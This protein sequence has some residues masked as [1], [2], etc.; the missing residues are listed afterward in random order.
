MNDI[1]LEKTDPRDLQKPPQTRGYKKKERTRNRLLD[2]GNILLAEKG[3]TFTASDVSKTA[4]VSI[5]TFYNY[6]DDTDMLIDAITEEQLFKMSEAVAN[7]AIDDPALRMALVACSVLRRA[8]DDNSWALLLLRLVARPAVYNQIN[9]YIRA[10]LKKGHSEGRF[11]SGA[12][13][14]TLDQWMGLLVMTIRR[15]VSGAARPDVVI[16]T[17]MKGLEALGVDTKEAKKIA[18]QAARI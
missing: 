16:A 14:T 18:R 11:H 5:G 8:Q 4:D 7:V 12:D 2:A 15:I 13:D 1:A 17:A 10:D 6:F 9:S 3:E